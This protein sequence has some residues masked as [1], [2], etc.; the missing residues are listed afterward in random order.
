MKRSGTETFGFLV[1]STK[2]DN[3]VMLESRAHMS[4]KKF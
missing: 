2:E 4:I 3:M 1:V